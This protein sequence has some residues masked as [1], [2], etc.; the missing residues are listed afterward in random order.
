MKNP[1]IATQSRQ[2]L[3]VRF[4]DMRPPTRFTPPVRGWIKAIREALGMSSAQLAKRLKIKQPTIAAME[5]SEMKGTIQLATLRRIAEAMN[6]T[7]V[8]A[9]VPKDPLETIVRERARKVARRRLQSVEHSMLLE[10]QSVPAKDFDARIDA[11]ARDM[12]PRTLWDDA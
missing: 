7:L 8:Y 5:Q 1:R 2:N 9:L 4:S 3:E 10:D 12:N 11:I 6:C